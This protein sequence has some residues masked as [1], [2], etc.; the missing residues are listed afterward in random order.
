MVQNKISRTAPRP[1]FARGR[2]LMNSQKLKINHREHKA[3]RDNLL[4]IK[5][6]SL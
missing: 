1:G 5:I 3:H 4:K 6:F 2:E